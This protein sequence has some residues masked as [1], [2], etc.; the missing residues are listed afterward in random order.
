MLPDILSDIPLRVSFLPM[1]GCAHFCSFCAD[2]AGRRMRPYP[3]GMI[4]ASVRSMGI[5][6]ESVALYNSC[7][8]LAYHWKQ[9]SELYTVNHIARLFTRAGA[10]EILLSSPGIEDTPAN[11]GIL[12][13]I[14]S[15]G[16]VG[17]MLSL[18]REHLLD[19]NRLA[20][21][22]F[23][24]RRL[25]T[26]MRCQ[27]RIVYTSPEERSR[28]M[29]IAETEL[30]R[31]KRA[32]Y[33][34]PGGFSI[35]AVPAAPLG[36]GRRIY[37]GGETVVDEREIEEYIIGMY[38]AEPFLKDHRF[39]TAG[40]YESFLRHAAVQFAGFYI[41]LLTPTPAGMEIALKVTDLDKTLKT[42]G[43]SH[44]SVYRYDE[45]AGRFTGRGSGSALHVLELLLFD[46]VK[47]DARAFSRYLDRKASGLNRNLASRV[48]AAFMA[49][50][51]MREKNALNDRMRMMIM[52]PGH[53]EFYRETL[54]TIVRMNHPALARD[55]AD[56]G[57]AAG[58]I[59]AEITGF[60][61]DI[62][63][64]M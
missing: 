11:R 42:R 28:L 8:G 31:G 46:L 6:P 58:D 17:T 9:G 14:G 24:A 47:C 50:D 5:R 43:L 27:V 37:F 20:A 63:W 35:E 26:K 38:R 36:R 40:G 48:F 45:T 34:S 29:H 7:D 10:K 22:L 16:V 2:N 51:F 44:A 13:G 59:F 62:G 56:A 64:K 57:V 60:L 19:R 53:L 23:T 32:S 18:N 61:A 39:M 30:S 15:T 41:I 54:D 3:F 4:D 25:S 21:F 12:D 1:S 49:S 52:N 55:C 33:R